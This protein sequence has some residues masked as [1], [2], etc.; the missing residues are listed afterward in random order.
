MLIFYSC[1]F[2]VGCSKPGAKLS[3]DLDQDVNSIIESNWSDSYGSLADYKIS[4]YLTDDDKKGI[5]PA[6]RNKACQAVAIDNANP[7]K[8]VDAVK[9]AIE[10]SNEYNASREMLFITALD[11]KKVEYFYEMIPF[12]TT[13]AGYQGQRRNDNALRADS[14]NGFEKLLATGAVFNTAIQSTYLNVLTGDIKSGANSI[15]SAVITQPLLRG[16]DRVVVLEKLTQAQRDTLYAV[17]DFNQF[18]KEFIV[19]VT[20]DYYLLL[21]KQDE[22]TTA[23]LNLELLENFLSNSKILSQYGRLPKHEL[24]QAIQDKN[25]AQNNLVQT[26]KE[27]EQMLDEFKLRLL[28]PQVQEITLDYAELEILNAS[29]PADLPMTNEKA[30]EYALNQRLD[31]IN[32]SDQVIDAHRKVYVA[33]DALKTDLSITGAFASDSESLTFGAEPGGLTKT[34]QNYEVFLKLDLPIDRK[35]EK[36]TY[37]RSLINLAQRQRSHQIITEQIKFDVQDS[38]RNMQESKTLLPILKQSTVLALERFNNTQKLLKVNRANT[39][40]VLDAQE[41]YIESHNDLTKTAV[42]YAIA[43][44][45]FFSNT[46]M[47][48]VNPD[49]RWT[50]EAAVSVK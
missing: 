35:Q 37:K 5:I 13:D 20:T 38:L 28:I 50:T 33:G 36:Y 45:E 46:G 2:A 40:D 8:L 42:A 15:F 16:A 12:S 25:E 30:I 27:Y 22:L 43:R 32:A 3:D 18:R 34:A 10:R 41:D 39:R 29:E 31:L 44:L 11:Q 47:L 17:R 6:K 14:E 49:G 48:W 24:Q 1:L 21:Q 23:K 26:Q 9:L 19:S 7:L 4:E